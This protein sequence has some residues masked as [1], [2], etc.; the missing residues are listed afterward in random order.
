MDALHAML[1]LCLFGL[2]VDLCLRA[3]AFSR[4]RKVPWYQPVWQ[5][6][7]AFADDRLNRIQNRLNWIS[8]VVPMTALA[9]LVLLRIDFEAITWIFGAAV[10]LP[11]LARGF[12]FLWLF[13]LCRAGSS[14]RATHAR[15]LIPFAAWLGIPTS[16][17]VIM[18]LTL[19]I[20]L[21]LLIGLVASLKSEKLGKKPGED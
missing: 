8:L 19:V 12:F 4:G 15:S 11:L 7:D 3:Y 13:R 9:V 20:S 1:Y 21:V 5:K 2:A 10:W 14:S 6:V 16:L 18:G 17:L